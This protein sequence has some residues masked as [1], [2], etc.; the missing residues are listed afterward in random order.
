[1]N[2]RKGKLIKPSWGKDKTIN[3]AIKEKLKTKVLQ[4]GL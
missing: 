4:S 2:A 1:L 3:R